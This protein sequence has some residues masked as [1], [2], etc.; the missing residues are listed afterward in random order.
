MPKRIR[1]H[2][3]WTAV[4]VAVAL[5]VITA[6]AQTESSGKTSKH[7][8]ESSKKLAAQL[9][10]QVQKTLQTEGEVDECYSM[11]DLKKTDPLHKLLVSMTEQNIKDVELFD[12]GAYL[13]MTLV[14]SSRSDKV[15]VIVRLNEDKCVSFDSDKAN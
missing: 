11:F 12:D 9:L 4:A 14:G 2:I 8:A 3:V 6:A 10:A 1:D 5:S 7:N 15:T 13:E